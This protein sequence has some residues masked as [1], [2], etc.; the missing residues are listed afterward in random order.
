LF[1]YNQFIPHVGNLCGVTGMD[2]QEDT[3]SGSGESDKNVCC[4]T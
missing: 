1:E 3:I 4:V 2:F